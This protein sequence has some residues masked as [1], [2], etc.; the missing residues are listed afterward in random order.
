[1]EHQTSSK[2]A[3]TRSRAKINFN[4][5]KENWWRFFW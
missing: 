1:M 4:H 3:E 5:L 2:Q